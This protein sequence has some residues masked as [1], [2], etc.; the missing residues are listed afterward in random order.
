MKFLGDRFRILKIKYL[1]FFIFQKTMQIG[2]VF[3]TGDKQ[4]E[5]ITINQCLFGLCIRKMKD[6]WAIANIDI[7]Q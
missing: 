2:T 1:N 3:C 5:N 6:V 4:G 7:T